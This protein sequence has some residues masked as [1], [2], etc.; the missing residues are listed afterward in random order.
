MAGRPTFNPRGAIG[1][2]SLIAASVGITATSTAVERK[3][4][5]VG[6]GN[7]GASR[8][9]VAFVAPPSGA[10]LL[11]A[12]L[13]FSSAQNHAAGETKTWRFQLKNKSAGTSLC[14][15][16]ASL[17]GVTIAATTYKVLPLNNGN[18]TLLAGAT[19][20]LSANAS[21]T[22]VPIPS[23]MLHLEYVPLNNA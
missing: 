15:Q 10:T 11:T 13:S 2:H 12:K 19:L 1:G 6:L 5:S 20:C 7:A 21:G 8:Q 18:S 17:S 14:K 9:Y 3:S 23:L 22:V 16:A 4:V